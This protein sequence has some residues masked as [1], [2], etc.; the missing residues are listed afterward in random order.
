MKSGIIDIVLARDREDPH[1]IV[2]N[3]LDEYL[4]KNENFIED[5]I[6]PHVQ[7]KPHGHLRIIGLYDYRLLLVNSREEFFTLELYHPFTKA[8][9]FLQFDNIKDALAEINKM[10]PKTY[11]IIYE[12]LKV[13]IIKFKTKN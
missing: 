10:D 8:M 5:T 2:D 7:R 13:K 6:H 1:F 4:M 9:M 12:L 3:Y 11:G